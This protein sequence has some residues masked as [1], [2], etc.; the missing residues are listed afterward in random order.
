MADYQLL[1]NGILRLSDGASIPLDPTNIDFQ[2]YL[3]WLAAG[4]TPDPTPV[5]P[6]PSIIPVAEFWARFFPA[7]QVAIQTAAVSNPAIAG[8]M[9]FAAVIGQVDL[10]AGPIV[11]SWTANLVSAGLITAARRSAILTP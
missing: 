4:N 7:E 1:P 8:A 10:L 3:E 5:P 2:V 11:S 6:P 9:A